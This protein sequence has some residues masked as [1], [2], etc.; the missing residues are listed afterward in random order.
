MIINKSNI[1]DH[2]IEK[3]VNLVKPRGLPICKLYIKNTV[4]PY[5]AE[6]HF[7]KHKEPYII[8]RIGH[9]SNFPIEFNLGKARQKRTGYRDYYK[10]KDRYECL[11]FILSHELFHWY[12]HKH[13]K[14]WHLIY[15]DLPKAER[16][17]DNYAFKKLEQF[18]KLRKEGLIKFK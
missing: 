4:Q 9:Y 1:P 14:L 6:Y 17:A 11:C 18:K 2:H 12:T 8:V 7:P 3:I 13:P 5:S 10:Y 16:I 15:K